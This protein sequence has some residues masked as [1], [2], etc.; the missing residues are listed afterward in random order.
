MLSE[1]AITHPKINAVDE[2]ESYKMG[3]H[4]IFIKYTG[5]LQKCMT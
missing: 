1:I 3:L 5:Y 4:K 2:H